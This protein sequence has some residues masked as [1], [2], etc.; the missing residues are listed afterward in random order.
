LVPSF[1]QKNCQLKLKFSRL[2]G[3]WASVDT[4]KSAAAKGS[5]CD[6]EMQMDASLIN[7]VEARLALIHEVVHI[8]RHQ[9]NPTETR[10]LD[11]GMAQVIEAEHIGLWPSDKAEKLVQNDRIFLSESNEDYS[12]RG[13]GYSTSYFFMKY[14]Y[15]HFGRT[16]LFR[17]L[18]K[19]N[20]SGWENIETALQTLSQQG[21]L[22]VPAKYLNRQSLW[23]NFSMALLLND[24]A[25][26]DYGLFL[27]DSRWI[28]EAGPTRLFSSSDSL[29]SLAQSEIVYRLNTSLSALRIKN[30]DGVAIFGLQYQPQFS[31]QKIDPMNAQDARTRFNSIIFVKE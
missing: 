26:S 28:K 5:A 16:D 22:R 7:K 6:Y 11:E 24:S 8:I 2:D 30:L 4:E 18:L 25:R 12:P 21:L 17:I 9:H 1:L 15:D 13:R 20:L 14:L 23:I 10:W 3:Y 29:S 19:S 27:M 31:I